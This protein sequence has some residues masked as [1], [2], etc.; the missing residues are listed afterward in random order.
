MINKT[1]EFQEKLN[2][3]FPNEYK[4]IGE[5]ITQHDKIE[6]LHL[7][8]NITSFV[9]PKT[10]YSKRHSCK[11]CSFKARKKTHEVFLKEVKDLVG[12]EYTVKSKYVSSSE[13][14]LM[15]HETCKQEYL[16]TPSKFLTG[17]RC[18]NCF[19]HT[20]RTSEDWRTELKA[21][22]NNKYDIM[23]D[24]TNNRTPMMH[25]HHTCN[26]QWK[27]SPSN[28]M[29]GH[30]CPKCAN[31]RI[32]NTLAKDSI[33]FKNEFETIANGEYELL[34]TYV[35]SA[36]KITVRHLKCNHIYETLP[37]NFITAGNRCP[38]CKVTSKGEE[39]IRTWLQGNN[40]NFEREKTF[41]DLVGKYGTKLRFDFEVVINNKNVLI[42]YDGR[43]HFK[44]DK[45]KKSWNNY[46]N[47][48]KTKARDV[49]KNKYCTDNGIELIRI[50]YYE[51]NNLEKILEDIIL[52]KDSETIRKFAIAS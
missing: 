48:K 14:I 17:R 13:K 29:K 49:I 41:E 25:I 44:P 24:Y 22:T 40:I 11:E 34:S 6:V 4:I 42:E 36:F 12:N 9:T 7:K 16:V 23:E 38:M 32:S 31:E 20:K 1:K 19:G 39:R 45:S 50:P 33:D 15:S 43:Q 5:Y 28:I 37:G 3:R 30:R 18:P 52:E 47:F 2:D 10:L 21:L 8:C 51:Y 26:T 27:C 35:R 46:E